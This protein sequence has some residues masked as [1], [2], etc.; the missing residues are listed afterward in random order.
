MTPD[1]AKTPVMGK[2]S[3]FTI[4]VLDSHYTVDPTL[5][6]FLEHE[7]YPILLAV[8]AKDAMEQARRFQPDLV[9][10]DCELEHLDCL[11]LLPE[12]LLESPSSAVILLAT[13]PSVADV[14]EAIKL[15][16]VD[17]FERP[18]DLKRLKGAIELQKALFRAF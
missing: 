6:N 13:K 9:L 10:I 17:F 11:A 2:N 4:L 14:V 3:F 7:G 8:K 1:T 15:G 18:L 5:K 12:V 16:A